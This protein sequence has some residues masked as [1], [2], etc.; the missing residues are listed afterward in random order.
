MY[1]FGTGR[2]VVVKGNKDYHEMRT[3]LFLLVVIRLTLNFSQ[4]HS[5]R[6]LIAKSLKPKLP[7]AHV[8]TLLQLAMWSQQKNPVISFSVVSLT[9][10][11]IFWSFTLLY[12]LLYYQGSISMAN[13]P[14]QAFSDVPGLVSWDCS[15]SRFT[16]TALDSRSTGICHEKIQYCWNYEL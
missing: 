1:H 4:C 11:Q 16:A 12:S 13:E 5:H 14:S 6:Y 2:F 15:Q 8:S 3:N 7:Q 10:V 9:L